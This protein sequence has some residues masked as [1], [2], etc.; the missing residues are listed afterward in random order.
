MRD[1]V[2]KQKRVLTK[3]EKNVIKIMIVV[4]VC[5]L[6]VFAWLIYANDYYRA[7]PVAKK[8][9]Q[10]NDIVEIDKKENY[11]VFHKQSE[12]SDVGP[13]DGKGIIFYPGGKVEETAYA[14]LLLKLAEQGYEVYLVKMPAKL[15]IFGMN[16][17]ED[18]MEEATHIEEW[19]MMGHS[20]GGAMAAS[21]SAEH[22]AKVDQLVL[23]A[24]YS[25]EDLKEKEIKVFSFY[26]S[27][28]KVLNMESYEKYYSNFPDDV[29]EEIIDGGNHANYAH[30]GAQ[31]GDGKATITREEQQE[32]VLD[33]FLNAQ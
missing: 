11:Y 2:N 32:C 10:G 7:E 3:G 4:A 26:G 6:S 20:L 30:Y 29:V 22:D 18:I 13:G 31:E 8:A 21:F 19:T 9:M 33:I 15:A 14:Q 24:A 17:A 25:T 5:T 27:E 16:A 1:T 23:L 28:D 12:I